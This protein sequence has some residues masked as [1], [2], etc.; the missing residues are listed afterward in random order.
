M[1]RGSRAR[2]VG[3]RGQVWPHAMSLLGSGGTDGRLDFPQVLGRGA[4]A[5]R[6]RPS[7]RSSLAQPA[8]WYRRCLR[9]RSRCKPQNPT[10]AGGLFTNDRFDGNVT[11]GS[12][13]CLAGVSVEILRQRKARD[14]AYFKDA[15]ATR[16]L[17]PCRPS[18][19]RRPAGAPSASVRTEALA[20]PADTSATRVA[21]R[22]PHHPPK[23]G[24]QARPPYAPPTWWP[25]SSVRGTVKVGADFSLL[26]EPRTWPVWPCLAC[27][28]GRWEVALSA[29]CSPSST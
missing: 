5:G 11:A 7:I 20:G 3:R 4:T 28:Q 6:P 27:G 13:T 25:P 17:R 1:S 10:A 15:C 21:R 22:L 23:G 24:A 16:H 8:L 12:V 29:T 26:P 9:H 2:H 19:P 14:M 18:A